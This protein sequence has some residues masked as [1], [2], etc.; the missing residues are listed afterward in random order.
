M[1]VHSGELP[2][3]QLANFTFRKAVPT[4]PQLTAF[5][6]RF[7]TRL[8]EVEGKTATVSL[9]SGRHFCYFDESGESEGD[10]A[11]LPVVLC[12]H[13]LG[14]SKELWIEPAP[15][16]G[17]RLIA[18]DRLGHGGSSPQPVP[19]LFA[20]GVPEIAELLD[21]IGVDKFYVV[22]H[23]AG[24][25]WA[26]QVAAGLG[27]DRVLGA[28]TVSGQCDLYHDT[29][30][31]AG[32]REWKALVPSA[33]IANACSPDAGCWGGLVRNILLKR[34]M[35]SMFYSEKKDEDFGFKQLYTDSQRKSD[36]GCE[37]TWEAM[38]NNPF[39]VSK[40][41]YSVLHGCND[42]STPLGDIWRL[43]GKWDYDCSDYK[44]HFTV[45]NG[46]PELTLV[47]MAE[48]LARSVQQAE[49]VVMEGHG[50]TTIMMEQANIIEALVAGKAA[51]QLF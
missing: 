43:F 38:D 2:N 44:G 41:L 1:K 47:P 29:A 18:I 25:G 13:G 10:P 22:G 14:Q 20:D 40:N 16:P 4:Q 26:V 11:A 49:L 33:A 24:A 3:S 7:L 36:G 27:V 42:T 6:P 31:R 17:V 37:R 51:K 5:D 21:K 45:Y 39:F 9:A 34:V 32:T 12:L 30:P 23:S 50:H 35:G 48:Q 15:L 8:A 46:D 19:Y 28:A